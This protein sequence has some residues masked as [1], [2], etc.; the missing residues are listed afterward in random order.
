MLKRRF[1]LLSSL[2]GVMH[3]SCRRGCD[4][5]ADGKKKVMGKERRSKEQIFAESGD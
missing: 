5:K 3:S 2:R 1:T 4:G